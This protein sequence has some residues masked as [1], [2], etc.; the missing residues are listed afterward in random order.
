M[1][2]EFC[3]N[4]PSLRS[5]ASMTVLASSFHTPVVQA[6]GFA[7]IENSAS[8]M[9]NAFAGAAAV[10]EDASTIWFN[11][12]GMSYL[13]DHNGGKIELSS[14]LHRVATKT[15]FKDK[16]SAL[17]AAF[18]SFN[19]NDNKNNSN[20]AVSLIPNLYYMHPVND[21]LTFG[22]G[23]NAPFG[24]KT[25]YDD[26]WVGRYQG[27]KTAMKSL[28]INPSL[29]WKMNDKLSFAMGVSL[30]YFEVKFA[31]MVDSAGVCRKIGIGVA[32][33]T[34]SSIL[35][36]YCNQT[37]PRAAQYK[38]DTHTAV[39]ANGIGYGFNVGLLYQLSNRTRLGASYRSN[40]SHSLDGNVT[41]NTDI[42]LTPVI[43]QTGIKTFTDK[44]IEASID[45]PESVSFSLAH[46]ISS[47]LEL[48]A[49]ATWTGWSRFDELLITEK[50]SD[51]KVTHVSKKWDDITRVSIGVNYQYND[52][53]TLRTGFAFDQ[54]PAPPARYTTPGV[55]GNDRKWLSLGAGYKVNKRTRLDIGYSHLF[56]ERTAIDNPSESSYSVRGFYKNKVD[57]ISAQL[58]YTF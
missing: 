56:M 47:R 16:G 1:P 11:P 7:I 24:A 34:N 3:F 15:N 40:I 9:G 36:D 52:T 12:A 23:L 10:A 53:L 37:Y 4:S 18:A 20:T 32:S 55:Y 44:A 57:I 54:E 8:G 38:N 13:A 49:D 33:K 46:K 26:A 31:S 48:L 43:A 2:R 6:A 17:P 29:A 22:I 27:T 39:E 41:Y 35:L 25:K 45:V 21:R 51:N 50:D 14:S 58:N 28:N 5:Y 42:G 19:M 30:Q